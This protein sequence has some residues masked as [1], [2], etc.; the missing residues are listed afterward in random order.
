MPPSELIDPETDQLLWAESFERD[1]PEVL[2]LQSDV[3]RAVTREIKGELS[4]QE[5]ILFS[6]ARRVNAETHE[7]YLKGMFLLQKG[8]PEDIEKGMALLQEAVDKDPTDSLAHA[9]LALGYT[10]L[11]HGP[12]FPADAVQRAKA[13][14]L[15]ALAPAKIGEVLLEEGESTWKPPRFLDEHQFL[16]Q[17]ASESE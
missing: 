14:T 13:A 11:V 16:I 12:T 17:C 15:S 8:S 3:A 7:A 4:P 5:E 1:F 6:G 10:T 2:L 9:G